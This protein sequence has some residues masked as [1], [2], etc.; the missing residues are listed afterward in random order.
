MYAV[1]IRLQDGGYPDGVIAVALG[2]DP[3]QVPLMLQIAA[4]K[5]ARLFAEDEEPPIDLTEHQRSESAA[6]PRRGGG[7][8][9]RS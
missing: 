2:T 7:E 9:D 8:L 6:Q 4:T 5:L 1:A 3:E